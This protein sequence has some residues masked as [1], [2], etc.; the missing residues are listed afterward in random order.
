MWRGVGSNSGICVEYM[1]NAINVHLPVWIITNIQII[2]KQQEDLYSL[3]H[4]GKILFKFY[5]VY[6]YH[7]KIWTRVCEKKFIY[8]TE[9]SCQL[10]G[11]TSCTFT[12]VSRDIKQDIYGLVSDRYKILFILFSISITAFMNKCDIMTTNWLKYRIWLHSPIE[13]HSNTCCKMDCV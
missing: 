12:T 5:Y 8:A 7:F 9:E 1:L 4:N 6:F 11:T 10:T 3:Q 13:L 2:I